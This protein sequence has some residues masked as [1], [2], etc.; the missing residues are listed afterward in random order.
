[1]VLVR[2]GESQ[3]TVDRVVG[4]LNTCT[5]LSTLGRRQA[6]ALRRRLATTGEIAADVLVS[7]TMPR[8]RETAEIIAPALSLD[9]VEDAELCEHHP[10]EGD[11]LT[12]TTFVERYGSPDFERDPYLPMSPGGE[13]VFEF[14]FRVGR[15]LH[16][17]AKEH[18]GRSVVVACHGGVVDVAMRS[19]LRLPMVGQFDLYTQNT[20]LTE[21]SRREGRESWRLVRY[22]DVAHLAGLQADEDCAVPEG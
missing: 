13:S 14:H 10:G 9:V 12:F 5:G 16:R 1:M 7:S 18:E 11:G 15:A 2:H 8:A 17:L 3:V 4:G 6:D 22:N 19:L 21:F 20:S